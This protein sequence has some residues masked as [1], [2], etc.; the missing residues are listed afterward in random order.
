ME[1]NT[2]SGHDEKALAE[3]VRRACLEAALTAYEEA[4]MQGLCHEGAW[5]C[6]VGALQTLDVD[7]LLD[8]ERARSPMERDE[9]Q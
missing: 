5:E 6:A 9:R 3:A 1:A 8:E 4:S 7:A 2:V